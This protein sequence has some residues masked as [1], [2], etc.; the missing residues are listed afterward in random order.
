[1][2]ES[3]P[4]G[5]PTP[6]ILSGVNKGWHPL[7]HTLHTHL[8]RIDPEYRVD[9]VKE[10][11]GRLRYYFSTDTDCYTLMQTLVDFAESMSGH[12]CEDCGASGTT[13][14]K[15]WLLTQCEHCRNETRSFTP[16]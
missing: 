14:G 16:S 9:Q 2:S 8:K 13:S 4:E 15:G 10:K 5:F 1:M 3:L 11:F 7:V 12:I 6:A